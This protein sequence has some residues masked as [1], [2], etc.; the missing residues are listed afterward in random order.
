MLSKRI[1]SK[2]NYL[3]FDFSHFSKVSDE[4][5]VKLNKCKCTLKH[6]QLVERTVIFNSEALDKGAMALFG[7]KYGDSVRIRI[8][9]SK[10]L[11]GEFHKTLQVH[12]KLFL[13]VPVAAG[14]RRIEAIT[15]DAV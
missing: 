1:F 7:E 6:L 12:F 10:E 9:R 15:G 2:S 5:Y 3:R 14:I 13:K 4:E 11:C 8:W